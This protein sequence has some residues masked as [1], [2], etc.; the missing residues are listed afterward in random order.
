MDP[1]NLSV[2]DYFAPDDNVFLA[3]N[4]ADLG[5]GGNVL[6]PGSATYP[7]ELL[8]GGKDGNIFVINRDSMGGYNNQSNNVLQTVH[9]GTSQLDNIFCTP[10]YWN[11]L[12]YFHSNGAVLRAFSWKASGTAGQQLSSN[13]VSTGA[14]VFGQHGATPSLSANGNTN[15]IIWEIDNSAYVNT[16]PSTSGPA[17][18]HAYDATNLADELYNSAQAGS[19]DQAGLALKFTSPTIANGKVFV[20]TGS[21]LDIYGLLGP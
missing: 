13:A 12:V 6:V 10:V 17:V 3:T 20:P 19:R 21:E 14:T 2:I 7:H 11:G 16:N 5:S 4:D 18:L 1:T 9:I 15:G 8:G